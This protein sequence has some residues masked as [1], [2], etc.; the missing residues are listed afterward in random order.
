MEFEY[1]TYRTREGMFHHPCVNLTFRYKSASL[2][3]E[4]AIVDTGSDFILLPMSIAE[5]LG[6]E[7]DFESE[8][9][10]N[11]A[12]GGT[13]KAYSSRYPIELM[14]DQRGFRSY[15]WQTHVKFVEPEVTVLLGYRGF[16]DRF[17]ASFFGKRHTMKLEYA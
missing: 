15:S 12:C 11:C 17:N 5:V 3:Y 1:S 13:F 16:L 8:T 7:P 4:S 14:I 2:P 9:E 10:L 6:A